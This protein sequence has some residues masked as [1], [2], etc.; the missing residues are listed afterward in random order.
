MNI[1]VKKYGGTSV[2]T[3]ER[4]EKIAKKVVELKKKNK[5]IVVVSAPAGM[6]NDLLEKAKKIS[7]TPS[8]RELDMILSVGEQVSISLLSMA[9][10][11]LGEKSISFT[12][13][14]ASILTNENYNKAKI[15]KI[16]IKR[17]K[18]ELEKDNVVIL[19]GFQGVT[20]KNEITTLGRGGSD[21]TATAVAAALGLKEVDICTDVNGVYTSDPRIVNNAKKIQKISYEEMLEMADSGAKVLHGRCVEL[22]AK[23]NLKI[24]LRSSFT[25][26]I[27]TIVG[28]V[29]NMEKPII[30][31]ITLSK[32]ESKISIKGIPYSINV[33]NTIFKEIANEGINIDLIVENK[34]KD[35]ID[36][37]FTLSKNDFEKALCVSNKIKEK[38]K[39][40]NV[41]FNESVSKISVIGYGIKSNPGIAA[42]VFEVLS[43]EKIP[44]DMVSCSEIKI[45][46]IVSK[47]H[48]EIGLKKLHEKLI[49]K[50][51]EVEKYENL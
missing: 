47:E 48:S 40:K 25:E 34:V 36:I 39:A 51:K 22:A 24:H 44:I 23:N 9:I 13:W 43:N 3:V 45:S 31:G 12:G 37:S 41:E 26:E 7:K 14:Q 42:K 8:K 6:T 11:N 1:I 33:L 50:N 49:E 10:Q 16:N 21:I 38:L 20:K 27:G 19:A 30:K 5:I 15:K 29:K 4:I 18:K 28:G 35:E 2:A 46:C 32:N 17:I